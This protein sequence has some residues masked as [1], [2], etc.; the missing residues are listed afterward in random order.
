MFLTVALADMQAVYQYIV[1]L[2]LIEP[3]LYMYEIY[4]LLHQ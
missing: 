4:H 3:K 1:S 2:T